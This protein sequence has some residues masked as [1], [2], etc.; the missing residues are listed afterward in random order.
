ML[1]RQERMAIQA[2]DVE[3]IHAELRQRQRDRREQ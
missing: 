2:K 1:G 3:R